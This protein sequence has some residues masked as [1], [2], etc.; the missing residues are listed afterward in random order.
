MNKTVDK[1][2]QACTQAAQEGAEFTT[3]WDSILRTHSLVVSPP[4][5][6]F[7]DEQPHLDVRLRNGFWLRYCARSNDFSLRRA[8]LHR[9][10]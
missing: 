8:A 5:Q 7:E 1:L 3:I 9:C 10:F 6:T 2:V 4:I